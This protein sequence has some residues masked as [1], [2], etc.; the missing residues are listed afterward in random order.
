MTNRAL[1]LAVLVTLSLFTRTT[2]AQTYTFNNTAGAWSDSTH[3]LSVPGGIPNSASS[4]ARFNGSASY[5]VDVDGTYDVLALQYGAS[6]TGLINL[7]PVGGGSGTHLVRLNTGT[8]ANG[9]IVANDGKTTLYL[10]N[11][12]GN[13]TVGF[14]VGNAPEIRL[15]GGSLVNH[16]WEIQGSSTLTVNGQISATSGSGNTLTKVGSGTLTLTPSNAA[17]LG[18]WTGGLT[19]GQGT[20]NVNGGSFGAGTG[21]VTVNTGATLSGRGQINMTPSSSL[22]TTINGGG[23]LAPGTGVGVGQGRA[24]TITGN[25]DINGTGGL[26]MD[27]NSILSIKLFGT[28]FT[29]PDVNDIGLVTINGRATINT[30]KL[31]L[32]LSGVSATSFRTAAAG[33]PRTYR[34][35]TTTNSLSG[36]GPTPGFDLA[37][38]SISNLGSFSA[39]EWSFGT[40]DTTGDGNVMGFVT[41]NYT[42]VTEPEAILAVTSVLLLGFYK[43]RTKWRLA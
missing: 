20:V 31:S 42:P 7:R 3:W 33:I 13:Q 27:A 12:A 28:G 41:V 24:L 2:I 36:T 32:D 34:V 16:V 30:N 6:Q 4:I 35:L 37:G 22:N 21:P 39:G 18:V 8:D 38:F 43:Y 10:E 25:S 19:V 15:G 11:G 23:I 26:V 29:N 17:P 14:A 5:A 9:S 40:F 1:A